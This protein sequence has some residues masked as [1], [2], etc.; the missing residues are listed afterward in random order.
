M[1]DGVVVGRFIRDAMSIA[2]DL[3]KRLA[4]QVELAAGREL[5][6]ALV[7]IARIN[8]GLHHA[9]VENHGGALDVERGAHPGGGL[10]AHAG[11]VLVEVR[12]SDASRHDGVAGL[13]HIGVAG[14]AAAGQNDGLGRID[15]RVAAVGLEDGARDAALIFADEFH[16][17][18]TIL[19][20]IAGF[21]GDSGDFLNVVDA[22]AFGR[23]EMVALGGHVVHGAA[24]TPIAAVFNVQLD[25]GLNAMLG[26][27]IG[28]PFDHR[29]GILN[30]GVGDGRDILKRRIAVHLVEQAAFVDVLAGRSGPLRIDGADV[31]MA[32]GSLGALVNRDEV[33]AL[34]DGG[35]GGSHARHARAY[36]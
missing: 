32:R 22:L 7:D 2:V 11:V 31:I 28:K 21:F 25:V 26:V 1:A 20:G 13:H 33:R 10:H 4:A 15:L 36:D 34:V 12:G 5:C 27:E 18:K 6:R 29:T 23:H 35:S 16:Q 19:N 24:R 17:V 14:I 3:Q 9:A 30:P 8:A